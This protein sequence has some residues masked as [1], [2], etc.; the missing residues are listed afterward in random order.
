[1]RVAI[2]TTMLKSANEEVICTKLNIIFRFDQPLKN[3]YPM[4]YIE[5]LEYLDSK[6]HL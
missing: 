3:V 6:K 4:N 1:M 2:K 5:G